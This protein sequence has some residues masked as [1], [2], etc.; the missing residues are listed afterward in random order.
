MFFLPQPRQMSKAGE[1]KHLNTLVSGF[2][3]NVFPQFAGLMSMMLFPLLEPICNACLIAVF[4]FSIRSYYLIVSQLLSCHSPLHTHKAFFGSSKI[5]ILDN[6]FWPIWL[7]TLT[8]RH[9]FVSTLLYK[10]QQV[11]FSILFLWQSKREQLVFISYV[12]CG[13]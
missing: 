13:N 10:C 7:F 8:T 2:R 1:T 5:S 6:F 9:P 3:T 11:S 4:K 12:I